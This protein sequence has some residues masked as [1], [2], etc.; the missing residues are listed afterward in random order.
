MFQH[1]QQ[2]NKELINFL[3]E[4]NENVD[5]NDFVNKNFSLP[6]EKILNRIKSLVWVDKDLEYD[7]GLQEN[8][9][10]FQYYTNLL[11]KYLPIIHKPDC[12]V[13][14]LDFPKNEEDKA[15]I[16]EFIIDE[17]KSKLNVLCRLLTHMNIK[18]ELISPST[19][20]SSTTAA[21][22]NSQINIVIPTCSI[23]YKQPNSLFQ[24]FSGIIVADNYY[25]IYINDYEKE[26][27]FFKLSIIQLCKNT[28]TNITEILNQ[29]YGFLKLIK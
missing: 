18:Y 12:V 14:I 4:I 22:I 23:A 1:I 2:Y 6:D 13:Y 3:Y 10:L 8:M 17:I 15:N 16:D 29:N 26:L 25:N 9:N 11:N 19:S 28:E 7:T 21:T 20:T 27:N 5:W 24:S